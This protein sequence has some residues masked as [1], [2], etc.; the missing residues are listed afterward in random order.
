MS[1]I[2]K[3]N[4]YTFLS[5]YCIVPDK[6]IL[7]Y[8]SIVVISVHWIF[9]LNI[10]NVYLLYNLECNLLHNRDAF[11]CTIKNKIYINLNCLY[12]CDLYVWLIL[13]YTINVQ[14]KLGFE[15]C[16][17]T[18]YVH[19]FINICRKHTCLYTCLCLCGVWV[20]GCLAWYNLYTYMYILNTTYIII[21]TFYTRSC[22]CTLY[23]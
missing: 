14:V 19:I 9:K 18:I 22:I 17:F 3:T 23:V 15:L 10:A 11:Y 21:H 20:W 2:F 16:M 8:I 13:T 6:H 1:C 7:L 5:M 4:T 12:I